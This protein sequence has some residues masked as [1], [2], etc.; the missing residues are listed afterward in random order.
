MIRGRDLLTI[1]TTVVHLA[2]PDTRSLPFPMVKDW[3]PGPEL[4]ESRPPVR[5]G[6]PRNHLSGLRETEAA[7]SL[8]RFPYQSNQASD[9]II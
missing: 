8:H 3:S 4:R 9:G 5:E 7:P 1:R 6:E 2:I